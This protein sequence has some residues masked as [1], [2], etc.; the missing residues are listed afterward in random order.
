VS[1]LLAPHLTFQLAGIGRSDDAAG[2]PPAESVGNVPG[3]D[4]TARVSRRRGLAR[5]NHRMVPQS[6][7]P[8][9][10]ERPKDKSATVSKRHVRFG[11]GEDSRLP[12]HRLNRGGLFG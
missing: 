2:F 9:K 12:T 3:A 6:Q 7:R 1:S 11:A 8:A 5:R 10:T 4:P